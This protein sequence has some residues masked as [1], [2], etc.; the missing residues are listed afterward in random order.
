MTD[1]PIRFVLD[2][3]GAETLAQARELVER[4][5]GDGTVRV[6]RAACDLL[7]ALRPWDFQ[8][9]TVRRHCAELTLALAVFPLPPG[10]REP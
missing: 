5:R 7:E 2:A 3:L 10:M 6:G 1:D 8:R 4:G 9:P